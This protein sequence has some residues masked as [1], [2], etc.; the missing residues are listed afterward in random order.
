[1]V[2]LP[3]ITDPVFVKINYNWLDKRF[4]RI[5]RDKRDLPFIYLLLKITLVVL[6]LA[7]LLYTSLLPKW[8]WWLA[9]ITY[10]IINFIFRAPFG[11]MMHCISHRQLFRRKYRGFYFCIIWFLGPFLG[12]TPETYFSHHIGMHHAENNMPEDRSSTMFYQRDSLA[13][14]SRYLGHF[15][16]LGLIDLLSYLFSRNKKKLAHN[17]MA[18]ELTFFAF[19]LLMSFVNLHAT[20]A[21]FVVTFFISR[22]I[23]MLGNWTQ[24]S[25]IDPDD[26]SNPYKNCITTLNVKYN[27]RCWNDGYHTCHH[28][29]PGLH[30]TE[31]P[32][33]FQK[34]I[35]QYA[36][37]KAIVLD[38]YDFGHVFFALINKRYDWL[39]KHVVNINN[40]FSNDDE[41]IA[42]LKQRT[43]KFSPGVEILKQYK[44]A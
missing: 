8:A 36:A 11:L 9:A 34:N 22:T 12:H 5:I 7:L 31:H 23:M 14:F 42:L 2:P 29:K 40:S 13:D 17:A 25:L 28:A 26:P 16:A 35:H 21:V 37:E 41:I 38:G 6:P 33:E 27:R 24:H 4:L 19:C 15:L 20:I 18:G 1:M 10:Q 30:W 39:A 32:V 44:A 3:V 43:K